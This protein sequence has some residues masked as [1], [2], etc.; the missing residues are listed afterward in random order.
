MLNHTVLYLE[1]SKC[2]KCFSNPPPPTSFPDPQ[3]CILFQVISQVL[4]LRCIQMLFFLNK[5][6]R[7]ASNK[8]HHD[9]ELYC[10]DSVFIIQC[11]W[12]N[13]L[14]LMFCCKTSML[15]RNIEL[16]LIGMTCYVYIIMM[17]SG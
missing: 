1:L 10:L 16:F 13:T 17:H 6:R 15:S 5:K 4:M 3:P 2:V 11:A 8:T 14:H 9:Y 12:L 7:R